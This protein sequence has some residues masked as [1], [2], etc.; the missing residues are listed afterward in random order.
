MVLPYRNLQCAFSSVNVHHIC[1]IATNNC[2]ITGEIFFCTINMMGSL[3][4]LRAVNN[5]ALVND[6]TH[7]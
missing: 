3:R 2:D 5:A 6:E 4:G 1:Y 7:T